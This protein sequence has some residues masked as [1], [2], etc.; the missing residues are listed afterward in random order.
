MT[1]ER[2]VAVI[3]TSHTYQRPGH[4]TEGAF[5]QLIK[6][7]CAALKVR[8][9][10]EEMSLEALVQKDTSESLCEEIA[11]AAGL[12]HR[13]C[14]PD[15]EQRRALNIRGRQNI[16]WEGFSCDWSEQQIE[17]AVAADHAIRER[18]WFEQLSQ[19]NSW[20]VLFVCGADHLDGFCA[21]MKNKGVDIEVVARD[22]PAC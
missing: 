16:E 15:N 12:P 6:E 20:P 13:Y 1:R 22:W 3:G 14:D 17:Q 5:R 7:V 9:V 19:L 8:A 4:A 10:A 18:Y 21:M 2:T 11:K